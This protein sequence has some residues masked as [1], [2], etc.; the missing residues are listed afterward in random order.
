MIRPFKNLRKIRY[1]II[2]LTIA[3][4]LFIFLSF[5]V[6]ERN[7][8][9]KSHPNINYMTQTFIN[10]PKKH[11]LSFNR[12]SFSGDFKVKIFP[13]SESNFY[14]TLNDEKL[15]V[16]NTESFYNDL[17]LGSN[18]E[19]RFLLGIANQ[20]KYFKTKPIT[21]EVK[22]DRVYYNKVYNPYLKANEM[23]IIC[24]NKLYRNT[25]K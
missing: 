16:F 10:T 5:R 8:L 20:L 9:E 25:L 13:I 14:C 2:L 22:N 1:E 3:N 6:Y 21:I 15:K 24:H 7:L 23:R 4:I 11:F 17:Q 12:K 18:V 19:M